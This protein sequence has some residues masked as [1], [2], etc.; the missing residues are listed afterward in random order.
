MGT[1]KPSRGSVK[2]WAAVAKEDEHRDEVDEGP[3]A[4]EGD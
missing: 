1:L 3:A 4:Y 2:L